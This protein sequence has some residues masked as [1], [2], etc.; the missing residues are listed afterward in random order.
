MPIRR[1]WLESAPILVDIPTDGGQWSLP[2]YKRVFGD[3]RS[4]VSDYTTTLAVL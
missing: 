4:D 2:P 3:N 1:Y